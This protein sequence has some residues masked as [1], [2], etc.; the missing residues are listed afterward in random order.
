MS[1]PRRVLRI[2]RVISASDQASM[3][4]KTKAATPFLRQGG[5]L[6][7]DRDLGL[8]PNRYAAPANLV[9]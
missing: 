6:L 8:F 3:S 4:R 1:G 2:S 5:K 9:A 7:A